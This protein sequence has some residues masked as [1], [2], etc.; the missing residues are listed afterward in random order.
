MRGPWVSRKAKQED[1]VKPLVKVVVGRGGRGVEG[2]G[3][4]PAL[5]RCQ[6]GR[7][8]CGAARLSGA[9]AECGEGEV[10]REQVCGRE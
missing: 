4:E 5:D 10:G 1:G 7:A 3:N 6:V 8:W 2:L 9:H